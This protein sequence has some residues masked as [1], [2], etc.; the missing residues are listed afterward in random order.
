MDIFSNILFHASVIPAFQIANKHTLVL[1][2]HGESTWNLENKFTGWYDCP[3]SPKGIEEVTEAGKLV[4]AAGIAPDVAFT[5]LLKRAIRTCFE[6]LDQSDRVWIPVTKG[7]SHSSP[8]L[9]ILMRKWSTNS[10]F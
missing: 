3:L 1:V 6:V 2:R 8:R 9:L 5:S 7:K 4:K 10:K